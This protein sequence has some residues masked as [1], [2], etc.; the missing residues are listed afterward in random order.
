MRLLILL[1]FMLS[2]ASL[3]ARAQG[4]PFDE[5]FSGAATRYSINKA[6]LIA[7]AKTESSLNP[8]VIGPINK[9]G[10]YDIGLMQINSSWM[11][12]LRKY[13]ITNNDLLSGCTSI[14]VGAWIMANNISRHGATWRAVGAYNAS[15]NSKRELYVSKVQ[16]NLNAL[17]L[18]SN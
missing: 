4:T 2:V 5:C 6:L 10:T 18:A 15:T 16:K 13:G 3:P 8:S 14:Y 1:S 9:N 7:I 11:P 12:T 17:S